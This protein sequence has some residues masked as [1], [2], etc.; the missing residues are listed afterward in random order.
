MQSLVLVQC[1]VSALVALAF[2]SRV[3][4]A[5]NVPVRMYGACSISYVLAMLCS[6]L[7]LEYVNY[8]TQVR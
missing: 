7:A 6:N 5:D 4:D 8:P 2:R 3:V 1:A